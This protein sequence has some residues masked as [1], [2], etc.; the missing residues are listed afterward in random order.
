MPNNEEIER[1]LS[2][3]RE[4]YQRDEHV[5]RTRDL[6]RAALQSMRLLGTFRP[7]LAGPVF[8]GTA[9]RYAEI[10]LLL[11]TESDKDVEIF[12]LN[13]GIEFEPGVGHYY[14]GDQERVVSVLSVGMEQL[15]IRVAIFPAVDERQVLRYSAMGRPI[16][17]GNFDA[18]VALL[19]ESAS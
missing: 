17:R 1:E 13:Q 6:R 19:E 14:A 2:A 18:V 12:L 5:A 8:K 9:G 16:E 7:Y 10:D 15:T 4:I 11:F 3:Y